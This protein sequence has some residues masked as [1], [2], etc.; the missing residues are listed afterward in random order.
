MLLP[1]GQYAGICQQS[2]M[3]ESREKKT[4]CLE[5]LFRLSYAEQNGE[6][7]EL[8]AV[9]LEAQDVLLQIWLSDQAWDMAV[10]KLNKLGFNGDFHQPRITTEP[11]WLRCTHEEYKGRV[12]MK[13]ELAEFGGHV[14]K[15]P[16]KDILRT[17][18]SRWQ[19]DNSNAGVP[20]KP[21]KPL[22]P[23]ADDIPF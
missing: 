16:E 13:W 10:E 20:K 22:I 7:V 14:V 21:L 5:M 9:G 23:P 19:V 1:E 18:S 12:R 17:L 15:T 4:P 2:Y 3:N 6:A 8:T 11:V